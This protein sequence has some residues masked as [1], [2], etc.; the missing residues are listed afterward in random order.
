VSGALSVLLAAS[1]AGYGVWETRRHQRYLERIPLR[2]H[3]NGTRGKSSV[4]RL[5]AAG[6]RAGGMRVMAKTTGTIARMILPDGS[7]VDVYR[8]GHPN[9]VEQTRIVRR[10]ASEGVQALVVECMAVSPE[11][12]PLSE[13]R[14]IRSHVGVI[15][16]ARADHLD[17]MGPTVQ[18]VAMTLAQT[19]PL[20]GHLF[21]A[22]RAQAPILEQVARG[23]RSALHV[24]DVS[25]ATDADLAGFTY[26]EHADNVALALAVCSHL[27]VERS[28]ALRGMQTATPDPGVLRRYTVRCGDKQVTFVNAFAA[29]DPDS[30]LLIWNRLGLASSSPGERRIALLACR[31]DRLHRSDQLVRLAADSLDA[32]GLVLAGEST[33]AMALRAV[34]YGLA[35]ERVIDLGGLDAERVYERLLALSGER[36]TIVGMGN[37]VGLGTEICL[38]FTN[39]ALHG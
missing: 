11:L 37:M 24:V 23:R 26:V 20:D 30:T 14:L 38:H 27:D 33:A 13:L 18:D 34:S 12:Q 8:F 4:T 39:R 7:E 31:A 32:D 16:N 35:P 36:A 9:I 5:I 17:V 29:N 19:T 10:A 22:E 2:I 1:L 3:V 15:T 6:L 21:T 25:S 28:V